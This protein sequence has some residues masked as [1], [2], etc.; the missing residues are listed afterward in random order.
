VTNAET[1]VRDFWQWFVGH[2]A[3][4]NSLSKPDQSFWDVALDEL[5]KVDKRLRFELSNADVSPREYIVT[6]EGYV[7]A[8]PAAEMLVDHAPEIGGWEFLALKPP[9]G[10][11]FTTR[12]EGIFFDPAAMW[13]L[14]LD[15]PSNPQDLGLR[16]GI[17][18]LDSLDHTAAHNAVHVI[19]D[20]ALGERSAALDIQYTEIAN[21]PGNPESE[22]YIQLSELPDYII[23]RKRR[24]SPGP[25]RV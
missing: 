18:G 2:E 6:A 17:A 22:G 16:I 23:W 3:E 9:M 11:T 8:F 14:P 20:T 7:D 13:F 10:F 4:F 21:L 12:Y 1:S 15:S 19:L 5:K 24:L 25:A